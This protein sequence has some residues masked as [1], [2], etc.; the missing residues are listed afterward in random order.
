M[1]LGVICH[2][3]LLFWTGKFLTLGFMQ[4][5]IEEGRQWRAVSERCNCLCPGCLRSNLGRKT[6]ADWFNSLV[7]ALLGATRPDSVTAPAL[8][9]NS[10]VLWARPPARQPESRVQHLQANYHLSSY[11]LRCY[12]GSRAA[13]PP[14]HGSKNLVLRFLVLNQ[15][16]CGPQ[17]VGQ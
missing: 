5:N 11:A 6:S 4:V 3:L 14:D 8:A 16:H 2:C 10:A 1:Q 17:V 12:S 13:S 15:K 9:I 7:A